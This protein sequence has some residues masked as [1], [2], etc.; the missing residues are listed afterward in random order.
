MISG[1]GRELGVPEAFTGEQLQNGRGRREREASGG[2]GGSWRPSVEGGG[3]RDLEK[4]IKGKEGIWM[5]S[6]VSALEIN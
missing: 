4:K 6:A 2:E 5:R 1:V 3:M